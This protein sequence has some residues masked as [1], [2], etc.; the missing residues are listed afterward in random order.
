LRTKALGA[1]ARLAGAPTLH[2]IAGGRR[3]RAVAARSADGYLDVARRLRERVEL[4]IYPPGTDLPSA[5]VLADE[6]RVSPATVGRALRQ[7][8]ILG[9]TGGRRGR[10]RIVLGPGPLAAQSRAERVAAHLRQ[11][12]HAGSLG[13]GTRVRPETELARAFGVSRATV[14][15]AMRR[16]EN[17]GLIVQRSGRR[18]VA[19]NTEVPDTAFELVASELRRVLNEGR[20]RRGER[21][22]AEAALAEQQSVSR[23]TLRR[24]LGLLRDE[25]LVRSVPKL[26]WF[27]VDA[28]ERG[29]AR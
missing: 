8:D 14:R 9:L 4:E 20:Y 6:F 10:P 26:G 22:P 13:V 25:G 19:G 18:Y 2:H 16:L 11:E 29:T 21:L 1:D 24:A 23:P 12:I 27:V 5:S 28:G 17:D 3:E 15:E 7:L